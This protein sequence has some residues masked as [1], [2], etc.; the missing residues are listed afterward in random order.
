MVQHPCFHDPGTEPFPHEAPSPP[1]IHSVA[2]RFPQS[3]P[4]NTLEGSTHIGSH[5]PAYPLMHAPLAELTPCLVGA[6]SWP[7]A[8]RAVIEGL[9]VD[10]F[11]PHGPRSRDHL[12]LERGLPNRTLPSVGLLNPDTL[13]G[14]GLIAAAA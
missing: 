2:A 1:V 10:R 13:A 6:A 14:R 9:L 11:Q 4:V 5:D 8:V 7:Q 3:S 12:G